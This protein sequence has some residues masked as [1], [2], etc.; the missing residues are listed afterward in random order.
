VWKPT[1]PARVELDEVLDLIG[2]HVHDDGVQLLHKGIRVTD[3]AAVV[4][5]DL[6]NLLVS[7][8]QVLH[9]AQLVRGFLLGNPVHD[10]ATLAVVH[11]AE[12]LIGLVNVKHIHES[13][14][15][16]LVNL[17]LAVNLNQPLLEDGVGLSTIQSVLQPV[18][19][20]EDKGKALTL[21]VGTGRRLG[22]ENASQ[23][24][25]HPVLGGI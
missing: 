10:E 2:L 21:L 22:G 23:F 13:A 5:E 15:V 7:K 6:G 19:Q 25:K 3:G 20:D 17:N 4:G 24:V 14:G 9:L 11:E 16:C 12:V 8:P 18:P 1:N